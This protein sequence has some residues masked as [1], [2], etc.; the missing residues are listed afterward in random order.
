MESRIDRFD[1]LDKVLFICSNFEYYNNFGKCRPF[2]YSMNTDISYAAYTVNSENVQ[3][4]LK[5]AVLCELILYYHY[6]NLW[7]MLDEL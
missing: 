7:V 6:C 4:L 2:R 5:E 3:W 1:R